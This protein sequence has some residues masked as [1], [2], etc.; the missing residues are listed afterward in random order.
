M[1]NGVNKSGRIRGLIWT[2]IRSIAAKRKKIT[3]MDVVGGPVKSYEQARLNCFQM[4]RVGG[5]DRL[6]KGAPLGKQSIQ[7][8]Y[9]HRA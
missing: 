5:L 9:R 1:R 8:I 7:P 2:H 4:F 6:R 3:P